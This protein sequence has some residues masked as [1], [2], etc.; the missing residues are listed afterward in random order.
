MM[1]AE[2]LGDYF[3]ILSDNRDL[4]Y[5]KYFSEGSGSLSSITEYNSSNTYR[6]LDEELKNLLLSIGYSL[7]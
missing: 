5:N 7:V 2:D 3:R 6:L 1:V 4:N